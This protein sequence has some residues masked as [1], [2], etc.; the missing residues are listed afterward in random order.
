MSDAEQEMKV[1]DLEA[2]INETPEDEALEGDET[3]SENES[4]DEGT[5]SSGPTRLTYIQELEQ[6]LRASQDTL[7]RY[8]GAYKELETE[9]ENFMGRIERENAK[10]L[11]LL[12]GK[13]VSDLLDLMDNLDRSVMGTESSRNFDALSQ[14]I[15]MVQHQFGEKLTNLGVTTIETVGEAFDPNLHEAL[16]V[17]PTDDESKDDVV[18][19][20]YARGYKMGDRIIR[21]A[22]VQVG[23]YSG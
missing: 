14:G 2:L 16:G 3:V 18:V 23:R 17:S 13:L 22:K 21:P 10:K 20:E 11:E 15:K 7:S 19:M 8:I 9:K 5:A 4:E 12:R 1:E 6:R